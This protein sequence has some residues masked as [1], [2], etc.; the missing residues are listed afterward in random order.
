MIVGVGAAFPLARGLLPALLHAGAPAARTAGVTM[1]ATS[2]LLEQAAEAGAAAL[3]EVKSRAAELLP[4]WA[5]FEE[6][7]STSA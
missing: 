5:T 6:R 3:S 1:V 7:V 2:P 4:S